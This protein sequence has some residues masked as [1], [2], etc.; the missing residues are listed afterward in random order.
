MYKTLDLTTCHRKSTYDF[1]STFE[2]PFF[3]I[4]ANVDVTNLYQRCKA[5]GNSF[6]LASLHASQAVVNELE[7]F[8]LRI[9]E[10]EVRCHDLVHFGST[11]LYEDK[12]FGFCYFEYI[13]EQAAFLADANQRLRDFRSAKSF[14]PKLSDIH[15]VH[16]SVIPWIAFTSFKHARQVRPNDSIPKIVFGKRHQVGD[17]Q[18]MPIS[19]EVNHALMDGFHVGKYFQLLEEKTA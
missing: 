7:A 10:D 13:R 19:V 9:V 2:E 5:E 14:D 1:F 4:S 8:R 17:K 18:M 16:Y 11:V 15:M 3:N 6:F 12:S